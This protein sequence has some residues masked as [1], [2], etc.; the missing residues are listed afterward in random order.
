AAIWG[1]AA[2]V[3][4]PPPVP[5]LQ[6]LT[7]LPPAMPRSGPAQV[8]VVVDDISA[9]YTACGS[10][11]VKP[12][13][14]DQRLGLAL[15]GVPYDVWTLDD[16]LAGMAV[17]YRL[18]IFLDAFYLDDN[19][20]QQ[21]L[22]ALGQHKCT[23]LWIYGAGALDV[24]MSLRPMKY[25]TGFTLVRPLRPIA[26]AAAGDQAEGPAP[27]TD[28]GPLQVRIGGPE[29]Y[30]YGASVPVTP[31]FA[32]MD[33]RAD[34]RGTLVGTPY[35]GLAVGERDGLKSVWSAAPQLPASLLRS[36][37]LDADAHVFS[38]NGAGVYANR[39]LLAVRASTDGDQRVHLPHLAE[40]YDLATGKP[41]R[42]AATEFVVNMKAGE[43]KLFYW[44]TAPLATP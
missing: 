2:A 31:R 26:G 4:T 12:L 17:G 21:L 9:A 25:L 7:S 37:A 28:R 39:N 38:Q 13:L 36:I 18:Y 23:A 30:V 8:A 11:L 34:V 35:G 27:R 22:G 10:D 6:R 44:G 41:V 42:S 43:I 3:A 19:A 14:S 29:G 15:M 32:C 5:W 16:V 40:V 24:G 1:G 20:R 33:D